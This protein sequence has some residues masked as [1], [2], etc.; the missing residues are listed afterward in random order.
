MHDTVITRPADIP[1][2]RDCS[3]RRRLRDLDD[4]I[5][6]LRRIE[7]EQTGSQSES[8]YQAE[9][10]S[11]LDVIV[12]KAALNHGNVA[13]C[14]LCDQELEH[15]DETVD[16]LRALLDDLET[17]LVASRGMS[18]RRQSMIK[19]LGTER[20]GILDELRAKVVQL[21]VVAQQERAVSAG[22]ERS[23]RVAFLKGRV[24]QELE[25]GV[26]I[27]GD[28]SAL[29]ESER[30]Y[31]G[32]LARLEEL[33]EKDDPAV[34][35]REA[36]DSISAQIT[37]Y[38]RYLELEGSEHY[39]HLDSTNLTVEVQRPGGRVP[40]RRMGSAENWV[41]YHLATHLALHHWFTTKERPVPRFLMLD[42]PTQAF[43]PEEVVDASTDENAD[44][45]AVR[46][47]FSLMRDV[48]LELGGEFQIIVCDHANL[49]DEWFQN[50]VIGNWRNGVALI[51]ADWLNGPTT[52]P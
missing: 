44:W 15:P 11:A 16:E 32:Q 50:S 12:P 46:G 14:P 3:T 38:S 5:E 40:L 25:R 39:V 28:I 31:R 13:I 51:P 18:T 8:R 27:A 9:R 43:F 1:P 4:H 52:T 19:K 45:E 21:D 48:V 29:R 26:D 17:R 41:G 49:A 36:I 2:K 23:E 42:Q 22:R 47:Q 34:A 6:I 37:D 7:N 20:A 24:S 33:S 10:L 30:R 35:L